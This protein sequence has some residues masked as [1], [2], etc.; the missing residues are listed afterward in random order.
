MSQGCRPKPLGCGADKELGTSSPVSKLNQTRFERHNP[1]GETVD[2]KASTTLPGTVD[3]IVK[4][5][6]QSEPEK[7]QIG[8]EGADHEYKDIRIENAL[9]DGLGEEVRLESGAKVK[10]KITSEPEPIRFGKH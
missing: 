9:T 5:P 8:V 2:K 10:V 1:R 7:A 4:P 6:S 3:K